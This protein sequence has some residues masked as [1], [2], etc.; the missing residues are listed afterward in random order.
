MMPF[1]NGCMQIARRMMHLFTVQAG[2]NRTMCFL[3]SFAKVQ[4]AELQHNWLVSAY[5]VE[6]EQGPST[7]GEYYHQE[8]AQR[9]FDE[10]CHA[11]ESGKSFYRMAPSFYDTEQVMVHGARVKRRGGS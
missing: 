1:A 3:D 5:P 4:M 6:K 2:N 8:T 9:E 10:L 11:I 7:L